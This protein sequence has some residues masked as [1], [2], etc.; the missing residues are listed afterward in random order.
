MRLYIDANMAKSPLSKNISLRVNLT[1]TFEDSR[2][3][4]FI[5]R[6]TDGLNRQNLNT[7]VNNFLEDVSPLVRLDEETYEIF[8]DFLSKIE[9]EDN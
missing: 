5:K 4:W 6:K 2:K 7:Y 8:I 9:K 1:K 3:N